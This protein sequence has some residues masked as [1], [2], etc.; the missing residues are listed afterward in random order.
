MGI[1]ASFIPIF[2]K[3]QETQ[4]IGEARKFTSNVINMVLLVSTGIVVLILLFPQAIVKVFASGFEGETLKIA[5]DFTRIAALSIYFTALIY[6]F[7]GYLEVHKRF[8]PTVLAGLPLNLMMLFVIYLSSFTNIYVLSIG[9][10]VAVV[11]QFLF[12]VPWIRKTG[13]RHSF[14]L[15]P[16]E[17]NLK[18]MMYLA[19]PVIIGVSADQINVLVDRTLASQI[20]EGGISALTYSHRIIF[21]HPGHFCDSRRDGHVSENLQACSQKEYGRTK[22]YCRENHYYGRLD[23]HPGCC[24]HYDLFQTNY[25]IAVWQRGI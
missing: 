2:T 18:K 14:K 25:G 3:I 6:V 15:A 11:I 10:L 5:I 1:A 16:K 19:I 12:L 20:V 7:N 24:R 8:L 9:T 21:L 4:G 22:A 23:R 13:Y 17:K